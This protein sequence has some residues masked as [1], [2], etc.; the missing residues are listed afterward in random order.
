MRPN[1]ARALLL[2]LIV[3]TVIAF[4]A[5]DLDRYLT[6]EGMAAS[7]DAVLS[8]RAAHPAATAL[9]FMAAYIAMAAVSIPGASLLTLAGGAIF[10][11]GQGTVLVSFASSIGATLAFL[12]ARFILR[13]WVQA[14][15]GHRLEGLN[16]GIRKDGAWYLITLRLLPVLPFWVI[17][18]ALGL[19]PIGI[20]TFYWASQVGMLPATV[21]YV[22]AGTQLTQF[23]VG[24]GLIVALTL[25]AGFTFV[26]RR[27]VADI[28]ARRVYRPWNARRPR[29]Y[30]YNVVVI[31][32]GSAGL[33]ASYIASATK[34]R[35]ALVEKHRMGGDCLNTGCVPSKALIRSSTL[36]AQIARARHWGIAEA[37]AA[38]SFADVMDRVKR[39]IATVE[40]HDSPERY[41]RLG[42]DVRLGTATLT[43]PW[44]VEVRADGAVETLTTRSV[45]I[46]AGSRPAV[47]ALPGLAR[48]GYVTSDTVWDLREL[49]RRLVVLGGGPVGCELAQAFA[50]LGSKVTVVEAAARLL[51]RED[52]EVSAL[53][54]ARFAAEG[55]DV[56]TGCEALRASS[57]AGGRGL[58]VRHD[59]HEAALPY[60]TL[61]VAL[62][63]KAN[64]EGYGL[65]TLGI[66]PSQAGTLDTDAFLQTR[67]PNI[68]AC[69][70]V[71]GPYQFT[72]VASHQAW[73]ATVNALFG[74]LRRFKADYRVVPWATFTDPQVARV[75][76]SEEE[77][78]KAGTPYTASIYR[79]DDLDRA[80][81][82]GET[83]GFVKVLTRPGS[84]AILGAT[85]V[86][87]HAAEVI[88]E[89]VLAMTH[90]LGLTKVMSTIH[91]YPTFAEANKQAAGIWRRGA[92]TP[93]QERLLAAFHAWQ[94][95]ETGLKPVLHALPQALHPR[96]RARAQT[97]L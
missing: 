91:I 34:A 23:R 94:R 31:G 11:L 60:D 30:D 45:V 3:S 58:H 32:A 87:S 41:T 86:G 51:T 56:R 5:L 67:Y 92:V 88:A 49:P 40:P 52:P 71:A 62:G 33:I 10:G 84:D 25:L 66:G 55:I 50:R 79:L 43:S 47:P 20:W 6:V 37:K 39:V 80:I 28:T 65:E 85:C 76:L 53:L 26:A 59:G 75:G 27:V 81:A 72:H 69:G 18:L 2:A 68:Y 4:F 46:A 38:P 22:Y 14:R 77:A 13:D 12:S 78:R 70:D 82:D 24:A 15:L 48:A 44:T 42:V 8:Y 36:L 96:E 83:D 74:S 9:A 1:H 89:F 90:G 95:G 29:H 16:Q 35:V 19:T 21:I 73:Y 61:L 17:N 54:Q 7:R 97:P 64:I 93:G 63:R 57:T